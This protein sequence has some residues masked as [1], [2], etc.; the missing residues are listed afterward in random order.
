MQT[1]KLTITKEL[2]AS[3]ACWEKILDWFEVH[4]TTTD[5]ETLVI[6]T[7][8]GNELPVACGWANWLL[9]TFLE[10]N[11]RQEWIGLRRRMA[12]SEKKT[13]DITFSRRI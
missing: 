11:V 4:F 12:N 9:Q 10:E 13:H 1:P 8:K 7:Y 5:M 6:E 2:L 3:K